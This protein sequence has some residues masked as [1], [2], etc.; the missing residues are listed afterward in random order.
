MLLF[1]I[2]FFKRNT[3]SRNFMFAEIIRDYSFGHEKC[4][5]LGQLDYIFFAGDL[6]YRINLEWNETVK[7]IESKQWQIL[8]Q[9]DQ[10]KKVMSD[11]SAFGAFSEAPINF[12]PT[13][14]FLPDT[15]DQNGSRQYSPRRN[16]S[17]CDRILWSSSNGKLDVINYNCVE[18]ILSSDHNPVY[19]TFS[20]AINQDYIPKPLKEKPKLPF[21]IIFEHVMVDHSDKENADVELHVWADFADIPVKATI[22][23]KSKILPQISL[24]CF[25]QNAEYIQT[26]TVMF[27]AKI[28]KRQLGRKKKF[29]NFGK[30]K[31]TIISFLSGQ[32]TLG[33]TSILGHQ[34][35]FQCTLRKLG[36]TVG[37]LQGLVQ[38]IAWKKRIPFTSTK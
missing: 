16:P 6:N 30:L 17:Y 20:A 28:D 8:Q 13:F 22:S 38:L 1:S 33:L 37:Y 4:D 36:K 3:E 9:N 23:K 27:L 11:E 24:Q 34:K 12:P 18:S 26:K 2:F 25:I 29:P 35:K 32:C 10:L 14:K 7:M 5:L 31:L 15:A 21:M 19:A